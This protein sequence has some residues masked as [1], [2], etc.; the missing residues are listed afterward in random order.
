MAVQAQS[1][2]TE[3]I[4]AAATAQNAGEY[5]RAR[6]ILQLL[7]RDSPDDPD[8]LRRLAM[9]EAAD[10][11]L[12]GAMERI[13]TAVRLAP[14][15]LDIALA[16]AYI[17]FW[18]GEPSRSRDIVAEIVAQE[19]AY[20]ELAVLQNALSRVARQDSPRLR[21][22]SVGSG[23]SDITLRDGTS[24]T[25]NS[26]DVVAAFDVSR[27]DTVTFSVNREDRGLVDSRLGAR[28]DHRISNGYW[29]VAA[30]TVIDPDF[31][32]NWSLAGGGEMVAT[33]GLTGLMDMRV[34]EYDT[35][36]IVAVQP[37]FRLDLGG[38]VSV[39]GRAINLFGGGKDY[40]LGS[41]LRLDYR[42]EHSTSLFAVAASYPDVEADDVQQLRSLAAG[43]AVPLDNAVSLTAATTYEDRD[44]SYRRWSGTLALTYRFGPR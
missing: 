30:T 39:L 2:R 16:Q 34:A 6:E 29:Y 4:D 32:E 24:R 17:L 9:V 3:R 26:Q 7:L 27:N 35:G 28:V 10:G 40:R 15:D 43:V 41:S 42:R 22:L 37:G 38:D 14:G 12:D 36:T 33:G 25:W 44:N 8:L 5:S 20:P 19:P 18:R 11:D 13:E 31:Q 1:A 23:L 21:T